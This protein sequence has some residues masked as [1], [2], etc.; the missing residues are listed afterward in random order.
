MRKL[1]VLVA[2]SVAL[3]GACGGGDDNKTENASAGSD[4][5]AATSSGG[6]NFNDICA[7]RAGFAAPNPASFSGTSKDTFK[8]IESAFDT[9]VANAPSEI[10]ADVVVVVDAA[11]PFYALLKAN[12]YD[13]MAM[14][15]NPENQQKLQDLGAK[16][17]E[18]KVKAA[19]DR[20]NAWVTAH[21]K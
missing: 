1:I 6:G 12:D 8:N 19:S 9:A 16:F 11:R 5:T 10:K 18:E 4:T 21:C 15:S 13:F 7:A 2:L 17:Q 20:I 14:A 3:V